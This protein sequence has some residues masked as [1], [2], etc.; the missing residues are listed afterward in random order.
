MRVL[1]EICLS[2]STI[3]GVPKQK[4]RSPGENSILAASANPRGQCP[5]CM[6]AWVKNAVLQ[7]IGH[8]RSCPNNRHAQRLSACLKRAKSGSRP[9][10]FD[11]LVGAGDQIGGKIEPDRFRSLKVEDQEELARLVERD[12]TRARALENLMHITCHAR[13]ELA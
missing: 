5:F 1:T 7:S 8:F 10:L 2:A 6:S 9:I 12:V 3:T 11:H 4:G 13:G